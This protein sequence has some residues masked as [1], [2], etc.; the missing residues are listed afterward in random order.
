[1]LGRLL[2]QAFSPPPSS[3]TIGAL[4]RGTRSAMII[5]SRE[6]GAEQ[7]KNGMAAVVHALLAH[8]EQRELAMRRQGARSESALRGYPHARGNT[9]Q[10]RLPAL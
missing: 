4:L 3:T 9:F 1:M 6:S 5:S 10:V 8:V 2:R 7:A